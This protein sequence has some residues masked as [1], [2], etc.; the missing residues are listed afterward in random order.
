M[1][2]SF[3]FLWFWTKLA[4]NFLPSLIQINRHSTFVIRIVL[5][6]ESQ[7]ATK[8]ILRAVKL[9]Q[10]SYVTEYVALYKDTLGEITLQS[11]PYSDVT[12][13]FS[14]QGTFLRVVNAIDEQLMNTNHKTL[15]A[16][17]F[18][19]WKN[20]WIVAYPT[21]TILQSNNDPFCATDPALGALM[22]SIL[23]NGTLIAGNVEESKDFYRES[24]Y[25]TILNITLFFFLDFSTNFSFHRMHYSLFPFSCLTIFELNVGINWIP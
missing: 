21:A 14:N 5:T 9:C 17:S 11:L 7:K 2:L 18:R 12:D 4:L 22:N 24:M 23:A 25:V 8:I 6:I 19:S 1:E 15:V 3:L 10:T 16:I 13:Y 20:S